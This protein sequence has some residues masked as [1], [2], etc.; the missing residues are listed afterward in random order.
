MT[1]SGRG[2]GFGSAQP[3]IHSEKSSEEVS[4]P[5]IHS[6]EKNDRW[7]SGAAREALPTAIATTQPAFNFSDYPPDFFDFIIIEILSAFICSIP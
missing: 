7:L 5:A 1:Q 6:P 3:A 2:A 4:E